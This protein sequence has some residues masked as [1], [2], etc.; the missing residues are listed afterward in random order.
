MKL[1]WKGI[2]HREEELPKG[3]L[4]SQAVPFREPENLAEL[5]RQVKGFLPVV[6]GLAVVAIL[7]RWLLWGPPGW[8]GC[9]GV[10][11][12]VLFLPGLLVHEFL[13]ALC[14]PLSA[15]CGLWLAPREGALLVV[16][17]FPVSKARFLF[18]SLAPSMVL[19]VLPLVFWVAFPDLQGSAFTFGILN[20][21]SCTGDWLNVKNT[22]QQVPAGAMIQGSGLHSYWYPKEIMKKQY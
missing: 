22:V 18:L 6:L 1:I 17:T 2:Y 21:I 7:A 9:F 11:G 16:S 15:T 4:P 8:W 12:V 10:V 19:G 3:E 14:Y 5:N 13:H 20:L